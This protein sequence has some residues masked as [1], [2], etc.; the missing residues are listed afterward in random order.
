ME[1]RDIEAP[2]LSKPRG[3]E[4]AVLCGGVRQLLFLGGHVAFDQDRKIVHPGDLVPQMKVALQNLRTTLQAAG[5]NLS[6]LVKLTIHVTHVPTYRAH[7]AEI[8]KVWREVFGKHYPA[9]TLLGVVELME[10]GC[11]VEI[12]GIAAR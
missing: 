4:D 11:V 6:D 12:D 10:P 8:G 7:L 5:L 1:R 3:Y 2:G 9:M